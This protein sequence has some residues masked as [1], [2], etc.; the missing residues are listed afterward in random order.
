MELH[1]LLARGL[2]PKEYPPPFTSEPFAAYVSD[3]QITPVPQVGLKRLITTPAIHNLARPGGSRRRLHIPNPFAYIRVGKLLADHW[4][5]L[6]THM[7]RSPFSVSAPMMDPTGVRCLRA[8]IDGADL[9]LERARVRSAAKFSLRTDIARFYGSLYTHSIPWALDGKIAAKQSR[10]GGLANDLDEAMRD[11]QAGQTLGIPVG[12]DASL[13][14]A[15]LVASTIDQELYTKGL[16]GFRFM[17]DFE[18]GFATRIAADAALAVIE[19]VL[20]QYELAIN[21]AKTSIEPLPIEL[22][23]AWIAEIRTYPLDTITRNVAVTFFNR[24]FELKRQFPND[25]V[26]AYAVS[27]LRG[28]QV[29]DIWPT[30]RDLL[31]QC[32]LA[33]PGAIE[34]FVTLLEEADDAPT[35]AAIDGV[36]QTILEH[37]ADLSHGSELA[38]S[39]WTAIWFERPIPTALAKRVDGNP[40]PALAILALCARDKG[41]IRR[42]VQFPKWSDALTADSLYGPM[43]LLTYE[44]D[45]RGWLRPSAGSVVKG[46]PNFGPLLAANVSFFDQNVKAP[47]KTLVFGVPSMTLQVYGELPTPSVLVSNPP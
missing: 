32:A 27:R 2:L 19:E 24:V 1:D 18:F 4:A 12:P 42:N 11:L 7:K 17:D 23:R 45:R 30:L 8:R 3:K 10:H 29:N 14:V 40:D 9:A 44:A 38:W 46:D 35:Q 15:E 47:T 20:A 26:L 6:E 36:I 37:Q 41:L 43:W 13:V 22:E 31:S 39:I 28:A 21:L 34:A 25:P 33:E 5:T 16:R